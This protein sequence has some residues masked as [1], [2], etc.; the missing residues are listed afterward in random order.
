MDFTY[1][2]RDYFKQALDRFAG[3]EGSLPDH[4]ISNVESFIRKNSIPPNNITQNQIKTMLEQLSDQECYPDIYRH[5]TE[6]SAP[7]K[8][9]REKKELV[10]ILGKYRRAF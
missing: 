6:N 3:L 10:L 1:T 7:I 9:E 4:V 8:S 2:K 5:I